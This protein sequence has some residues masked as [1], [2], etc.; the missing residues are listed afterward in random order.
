[1]NMC[2]TLTNN[3]A[4]TVTATKTT[5]NNKNGT[6]FAHDRLSRAPLPANDALPKAQKHKRKLNGPPDVTLRKVIPRNA[7]GLILNLT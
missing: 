4:E 7:F 3:K 6:N 5:N 2:F 1:M